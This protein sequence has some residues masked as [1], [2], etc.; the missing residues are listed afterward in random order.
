MQRTLARNICYCAVLTVI[1]VLFQSAP[2]FFPLAGMALSPLSTL[3]VALASCE[4][5]SLGAASYAAAGLILL[6][7]YPEE[8]L[9]FFLATGAIGI[10]LGIFARSPVKAAAVTAGVLFAGMNALTYLAGISLF[11]DMTQGA[12]FLDSLP[13]YLLFS[14]AYAAVWAL[15][16]KYTVKMLARRGF[17]PK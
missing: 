14:L 2:V 9:I 11:G 16:T 10:P 5:K 12:S 7:I 17:F 6:L 4:S 8:A 15:I 1:A 13:P 3:P